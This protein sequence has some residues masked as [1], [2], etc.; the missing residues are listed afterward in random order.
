MASSVLLRPGQS[1]EVPITFEPD[2]YRRHEALVPFEVNGLY[3]VNVK[4]TGEGVPMRMEVANSAH[5]VFNLGSVSRG[6]GSIKVLPIVNKGKARALV[7]L[8]PAAETLR[9]L[10]IELMPSAPF[11][12]R[13]REVAEIT[14][15]YKPP[16]RMKPWKQDLLIKVGAAAARRGA[17]VRWHVAKKRGDS[18]RL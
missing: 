11:T 4:L 9:E 10:H 17:G 8:S 13:P 2:E 16:A 15:F 3:T 12:M 7:D 5:K 14:F 1:T 18:A 6:Q